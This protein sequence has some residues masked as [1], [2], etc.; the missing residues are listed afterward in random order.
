MQ[1]T[2]NDI[3]VQLVVVVV[4]AGVEVATVTKADMAKATEVLFNSDETLGCTFL[5]CRTVDFL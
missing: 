5:L 4:V 2:K 1:L 3:L